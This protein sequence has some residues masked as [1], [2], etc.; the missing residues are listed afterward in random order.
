MHGEGGEVLFYRGLAQFLGDD[1]PLFGLQAYG[2]DAFSPPDTSVEAMASRYIDEIRRHQ[3]DGPY[4]LAGHCFGG[5]VAFEMARQLQAQGLEVAMLAM[6]D[7]AGP[8][9]TRTL[10]DSL[11]NL[12]M[13]MRQDLGGLI[14][15]L[16]KVEVPYRLQQLASSVSERLAPNG[17]PSEPETN[18][19]EL[20]LQAIGEAI[21]V[22]YWDYEPRTYEGRIVCFVNS[23]RG[24]LNFNRWSRLASEGVETYDFP[25]DPQTS[26]EEPSV[27]YLADS[28]R[29][30]MDRLLN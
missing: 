15:Y 23:Q 17:G 2:L 11:G 9:A 7:G 22:A 21:A 13:A 28:L 1:Q 6:L 12:M 25:G 4:Y 24:L 14:K 3:A 29:Q 18:Q 5:V 30:Y 8:P 19:I 27:G 16:A 10:S 20:V 26:F